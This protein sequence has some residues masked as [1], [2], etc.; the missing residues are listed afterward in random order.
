M[1]RNVPQSADGNASDGQ[2]HH[3]AIPWKRV[4][5]R[6]NGRGRSR[7]LSG[8]HMTLAAHSRNTLNCR[9]LFVNIEFAANCVGRSC[10]E[11][12]CG[13]SRVWVP[14]SITQVGVVAQLLTPTE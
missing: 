9:Q 12:Y 11:P 10:P 4:R 5:L 8:K 13:S 3:I 7:Q 6:R 14:G 1:P 2:R